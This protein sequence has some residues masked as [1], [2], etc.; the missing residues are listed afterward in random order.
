MKSYHGCSFSSTQFVRRSKVHSLTRSGSI[1]DDGEGGG[2]VTLGHSGQKMLLLR[3]NKARVD[4]NKVN[5]P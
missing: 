4:L 1:E 5:N 3:K 2:G